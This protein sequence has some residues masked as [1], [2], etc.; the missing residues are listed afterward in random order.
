MMP[1]RAAIRPSTSRSCPVAERASAFLP[2]GRLTHHSKSGESSLAET[3]CWPRA[4]ADRS[5]RLLRTRDWPRSTAS[6]IGRFSITSADMLQCASR[7]GTPLP[8][9]MLS[10]LVKRAVLMPRVSRSNVI[11]SAQQHMPGDIGVSGP[12]RQQNQIAVQGRLPQW[13]RSGTATALAGKSLDA[14]MI[15]VSSRAAPGR[16][17]SKT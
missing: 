5:T 4:T 14:I 10:V 8:A 1:S 11:G 16:N 7:M 2:A 3:A 12:S 17:V 9:R 13:Q 6:R 15:R